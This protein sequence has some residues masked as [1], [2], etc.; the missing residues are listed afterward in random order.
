MFQ[1]F[2]VQWKK[3]SWEEFECPVQKV[4]TWNYIF[5]MMDWW[6]SRSP[7]PEAG[8]SRNQKLL[9]LETSD[10]EIQD[11]LERKHWHSPSRP[12]DYSTKHICQKGLKYPSIQA[13]S[14]FRKK[15]LIDLTKCIKFWLIQ[16]TLFTRHSGQQT[17]P[18][19]MNCNQSSQEH[20]RV[21]ITKHEFWVFLSLI[22]AAVVLTVCVTNS[23][24][25]DSNTTL[26]FN[27]ALIYAFSCDL[28]I[29]NFSGVLKKP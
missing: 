22:A 24:V 3:L 23:Y 5:R 26:A 20:L 15:L 13:K 19:A 17:A 25:F 11:V 12:K 7:R 27:L 4:L 2:Q 18:R 28:N 16:E 21:K 8:V 10:T 9:K 29:S 6:R 1:N 14:I